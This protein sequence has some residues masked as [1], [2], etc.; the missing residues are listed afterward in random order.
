MTI[1][2]DVADAITRHQ[3][4]QKLLYQ[5]SV[6]DVCESLTEFA[7]GGQIALSAATFGRLCLDPKRLHSTMRSV[8]VFLGRDK[9]AALRQRNAVLNL[10]ERIFQCALNSWYCI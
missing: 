9:Q 3:I 7:K 4:T 6:Y 8:E 10:Q 5:G 2:T 1:H